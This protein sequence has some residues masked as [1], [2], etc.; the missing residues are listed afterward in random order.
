V[1]RVTFSLIDMTMSWDKNS[2]MTMSGGDRG[3]YKGLGSTGIGIK[4]QSVYLRPSLI[5]NGKS[6]SSV[7]R[8]KPID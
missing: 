3:R 1:V 5:I 8:S 4:Q 2:K 6:K 7:I